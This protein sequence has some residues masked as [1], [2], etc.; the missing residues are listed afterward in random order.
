MDDSYVTFLVL[1]VLLVAVDGQLIYQGGKRYMRK[2]YEPA[3]ATAMMRLATVLFHL[4]VLGM[5]L[6]VS[7]VDFD[8]GDPAKNIV[9]KLGVVLLMLAV[10]HA[11]TMAI[12]S[13]IRE[14][15]LQRQLADEM[16][17]EHRIFEERHSHV[18]EPH[19]QHTVIESPRTP[20]STT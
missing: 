4:V 12:L 15:Q 10:A 1:G 17:V 20:Y 5:L 8:T 14:R 3:E 6:L 11:G 7:L 2:A 13:R 9:A 18:S 16:A 19:V